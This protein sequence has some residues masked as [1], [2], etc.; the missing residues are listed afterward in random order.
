MSVI[1]VPRCIADGEGVEVPTSLEPSDR[2]VVN[3]SDS[4]SKGTI[5]QVKP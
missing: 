3:P 1:T 5:V 2:L 4:L